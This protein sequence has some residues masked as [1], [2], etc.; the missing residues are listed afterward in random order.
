MRLSKL[1]QI[2]L[3]THSVVYS[4]L[5]ECGNTPSYQGQQIGLGET[6]DVAFSVWM[7]LLCVHAVNII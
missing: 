4:A 1:Y 7:E 2:N 3:L 5:Q 6:L